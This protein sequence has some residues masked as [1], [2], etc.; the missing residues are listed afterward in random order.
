MLCKSSDM[1]ICNVY[2]VLNPVYKNVVNSSLDEYIV[3]RISYNHG[4][5][6]SSYNR[7]HCLST[8]KEPSL[9]LVVKTNI[10]ASYVQQDTLSIHRWV[11]P[12]KRN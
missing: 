12:A 3:W 7:N 1:R 10:P 8:M 11:T 9:P 4:L 2:P 5:N 6:G